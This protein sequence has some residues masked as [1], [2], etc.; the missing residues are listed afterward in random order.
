MLTIA[1]IGQRSTILIHRKDQ[2][3][4]L[5]V[6]RV[7]SKLKVSSSSYRPLP[8]IIAP[9]VQVL[10]SSRTCQSYYQDNSS[11][12]TLRRLHTSFQISSSSGAPQSGSLAVPN[13][14]RRRDELWKQE[15]ERQSSLRSKHGPV[16]V[17]FPDGSSKQQIDANTTFASLITQDSINPIVGIYL[18]NG[19]LVELSRSL[20][21]FGPKDVTITRYIYFQDTE[22]K[23]M[24]WHTS[25]H[26]LGGAV[27]MLHFPQWD[28]ES[29]THLKS[30]PIDTKRVSK[31][32]L[33]E[34]L[35]PLLDD[36][37][38]LSDPPGGF[39]YDFH[40]PTH[41][42][43]D[44]F[45]KL[46]KLAIQSF[47]K[48]KFP[49]ERLSVSRSFALDMF[50]YNPFKVALINKI[51][52]S[53]TIALYKCGPFIDLCKGPHLPNVSLIG[54]FKLLRGSGAYWQGHSE[55]PYLQRLYAIS[56]PTKDQF[57]QW[58]TLREEAERRDH[59]AIGKAQSLFMFHEFS[60][61]SPFFLPHGTKIFNKLIETMRSEY[62]TRGY[63]EIVTP[64]IFDKRL[65]QTSGHWDH[66][67]ENMFLIK[68]GDDDDDK[69]AKKIVEGHSSSGCSHHS[70]AEG[71]TEEPFSTGLKPMNCPGHCLTF[72]A[73]SKSY[74]D[75][76]VRY[77]D[78]SSLHRN[79]A[80]GTLTGLTR[81]RRFH[82]DDAHIF[83]TPEQ[84]EA[85]LHGVMDMVEHL[86]GRVFG[87][88]YEIFVSTRP[89]SSMGSDEEWSNAE[90]ALMSAVKSVGRQFTINAGDG[91]FYGPKIDFIVT[92]ALHRKHQCATIQ[93]DFQ[94]PQRFGLTYVAA[95]G[96]KKV[97]VIIHRA[98][99]GSIERMFAML[100]EHY[101]GKWPF[102]LSPRQIAICTV[103][104]KHVEY[105]KDLL[106]QLKKDFN[107]ELFMDDQ[108][109]PNKIRLAQMAQ[110]NYIL[111]VGNNEME[112]K[113]IS[114]R[115]R[116]GTQ[117]GSMKLESLH[118]HFETVL[119]DWK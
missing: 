74:R 28:S 108:K 73:E 94:L 30:V 35:V 29:L 19:S 60:P 119:A 101:A 107:V 70:H 102:W 90:Q 40:L 11:I 78:F 69:I 14:I 13:A 85:E 54:S 46:E 1:S 36:G 59:R 110:F 15:K 64:L 98:V 25:A 76:P 31:E 86:Y 6:A 113:T 117:L 55:N 77:S 72:K 23:Q 84:I 95:D 66:Y 24:F 37:P 47:V 9:F 3:V 39:Y 82:Q 62:V 56:F 109:L 83:C 91:A 87:F 44:S 21:E 5:K 80:K 112:E 26:V 97:P 2:K 41:L 99:M 68:G 8:S 57:E 16:T 65:W 53:E 88:P 51:P 93:L 38:P 71:E 58:K 67:R 118:S 81:V 61:G 17:H 116:D 115:Q 114:V 42:K 89:E 79:E 18:D 45:E 63:D 43:E 75:L 96:T 106:N 52:K 12:G 34:R 50:S 100:C 10:S 27:E 103:S 111:V 22:G 7:K 32:S 105:A 92:D 33:S 49:I 104:E 4:L 20:G 48:R